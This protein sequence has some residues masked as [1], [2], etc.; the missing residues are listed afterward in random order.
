MG[1]EIPWRTRI[2]PGLRLMHAHGLVVH[3]DAVIGAGVTLRQAVTIGK[4]RDDG[5]PP[6]IGNN[7]D[8]GAGSIAI[9]DIVIGDHAVIGA[10]AVVTK[11]VEHGC[12]VVGNPAK[13]IS[14]KSDVEPT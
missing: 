3:D 8:F 12:T 11:D 1:I 14:R 10:G 6:T 4:A 13:V 2:G 9:G 7:V 5:Q